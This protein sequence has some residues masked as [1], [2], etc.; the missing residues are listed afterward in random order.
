MHDASWYCSS[1]Q[2]HKDSNIMACVLELQYH[3]IT[4]AIAVEHGSSNVWWYYNSIQLHKDNNIMV[5]VGLYQYDIILM[6][7]F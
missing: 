3:D 4:I 7:A 1:I 2:L 5:C 6:V